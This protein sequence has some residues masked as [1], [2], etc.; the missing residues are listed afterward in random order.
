MNLQIG[1]ETLT[2]ILADKSSVR[3]L[4]ELLKQGPL[5]LSLE[6]Y[7]GMEKVGP[8]GTSLP[9]NNEQIVTAPGHIIR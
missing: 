6:D 7:A 3:A 2:V 9:Q 8:L 4:A 5:T 1:E